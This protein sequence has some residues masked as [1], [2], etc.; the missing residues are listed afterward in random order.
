MK[1]T[2]DYFF[3]KEIKIQK[4]TPNLYNHYENFPTNS[5]TKSQHIIRDPHERKTVKKNFEYRP[6]NIMHKIDML[7]EKI[8]NSLLFSERNLKN[9]PKNKNENNF[10]KNKENSFLIQTSQQK[11]Q[12]QKSISPINN[13]ILIENSTRQNRNEDQFERGTIKKQ[14]KENDNSFS[15]NMKTKIKKIRSQTGFDMNSIINDIYSLLN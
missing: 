15:P 1:Q 14:T 10:F 8:D 5:R 12:Y 4:N 11:F 6:R 13:R 3:L 2:N 9:S 7:S